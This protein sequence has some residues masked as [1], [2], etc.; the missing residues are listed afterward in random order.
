MNSSVNPDWG[1]CRISQRGRYCG[2]RTWNFLTLS[3]RTRNNFPQ[4]PDAYDPAV[5]V[6]VEHLSFCFDLFV[7]FLIWLRAG[8][9]NPTSRYLQH[10][11][12]KLHDSLR[13]CE[14]EQHCEIAHSSRFTAVAIE[15]PVCPAAMS[16]FSVRQPLLRSGQVPVYQ[17]FLRWSRFR[18]T[19][20]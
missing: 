1:R 9:P 15:G 6:D 17:F 8:L 2:R 3:C 14:H 20:I 4:D 13:P 11:A 10:Q 18:P 7:N 19:Y 5:D 16:T 12:L